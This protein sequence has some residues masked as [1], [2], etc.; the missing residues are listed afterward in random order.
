VASLDS[1]A[2]AEPVIEFESTAFMGPVPESWS[3]D[4]QSILFGMQN[5]DSGKDLWWLPLSTRKPVAFARTRF[6]ERLG[7]LSP[8]GRWVA[9][10]SNDTGKSEIFVQPISP[11]GPKQVISNGGGQ[12]PRWRDD[13]RELFYLSSSGTMMSASFTLTGT[14]LHAGTPVALFDAMITS[15]PHSLDYW[16]YAVTKDGQRFLI[17]RRPAASAR[18]AANPIVV[19]LNWTAAA[20]LSR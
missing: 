4:G 14:T 13:G 19:V 15:V 18:Q 17:T 8:N 16:P 1:T 20:P 3:P 11:A 6:N 7:R 2:N 5:E 12:L 9:F 10:I